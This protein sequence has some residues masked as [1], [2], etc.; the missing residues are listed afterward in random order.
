MADLSKIKLNGTEYDLKDA[1]ARA[2][3]ENIPTKTSDLSND[4][5]FLTGLFGTTKENDIDFPYVTPDNVHTALL[6]NRNIIVVHTDN[7]L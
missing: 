6:D 3:L 2:G 7:T 1:V 4:S 5:G